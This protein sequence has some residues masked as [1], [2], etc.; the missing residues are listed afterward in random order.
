VPGVLAVA[1]AEL[2]GLLSDQEVEVVIGGAGR[3][4]ERIV[5]HAATAEARARLSEALVERRTLNPSELDGIVTPV[6]PK[7]TDLFDESEWWTLRVDGS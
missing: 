7:Y 5:T 6:L 1:K 4:A 3:L 2:G